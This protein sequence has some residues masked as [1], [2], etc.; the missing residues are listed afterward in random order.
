MKQKILILTVLALIQLCVPAWMISKQEW[1]LAYG[2]S[3][4][5]K[6]APVDPN[7]LFRGNYIQLNFEAEQKELP[8]QF[9]RD[10]DGS[11]RWVELETQADGFAKVKQVSAAKPS[12]KDAFKANV[13]WGRL[14]FPFDRYYTDETESVQ[15]EKA[16]REKNR[17]SNK[18]IEA[19]ATIRVDGENAALEELY[20][21]GKSLKDY[22]KE[23]KK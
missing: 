7:D 14:V 8:A 9:N 3:F 20:L 5:L 1:I 12:G 16:Y 17:R 22:L 13:K 2:K 23:N 18:D 19:W 10:H 11:T 21:D 4:K 15:A 6:T